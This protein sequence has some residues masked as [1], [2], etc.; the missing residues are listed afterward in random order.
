MLSVKYARIKELDQG[1]EPDGQSNAGEALK[2]LMRYVETAELYRIALGLYDLELAYMVVTHAQARLLL[3]H[4]QR[5][6]EEI[7]RGTQEST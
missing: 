5:F 3:S 4:G 2:H 6:E 7:C 1:D